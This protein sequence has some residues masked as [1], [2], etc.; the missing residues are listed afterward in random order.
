MSNSGSSSLRPAWKG[1]RGFQPP[2]TVTSDGPTSR[3]RSSSIASRDSNKFSALGDDDDDFISVSGKK[4][5]DRDRHSNN[6]NHNN[7]DAPKVNSRGE[8]FRSSY[9]GGGG[10]G[11]NSKGGRSLADLVSKVPEGIPRSASTGYPTEERAAPRGGRRYSTGDPTTDDARP[12]RSNEPSAYKQAVD[13]AKVICYTRE[14]LLALRP[15]PAMD[16]GSPPPHLKH[17]EAP[18]LFSELPQDPGKHCSI[19]S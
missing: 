10:G 3:G 9:G 1:G 7:N 5:R 14:K 15:R 19:L 4:S 16:L 8:A 17:V 6:N 2:P 12:Q 13:A 18:A 11:R